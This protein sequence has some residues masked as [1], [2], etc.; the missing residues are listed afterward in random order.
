MFP[1]DV[2]LVLVI[3]TTFPTVMNPA[4]AGLVGAPPPGTATIKADD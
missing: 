4:L 3:G 1:N 2:Q